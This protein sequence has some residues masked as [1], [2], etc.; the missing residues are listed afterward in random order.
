M[1]FFRFYE[2]RPHRPE[3]WLSKNKLHRLSPPPPCTRGH[4]RSSGEWAS[5]PAHHSWEAP[6][7]PSHFE[8]TCNGAGRPNAGFV[9][10]RGILEESSPEKES[11]EEKCTGT[12]NEVIQVA[13]TPTTPLNALVEWMASGAELPCRVKAN[14]DD[15]RQAQELL[16]KREEA[17]A[18]SSS[19]PLSLGHATPPTDGGEPNG[20][21][22]MEPPEINATK[23]KNS[24]ARLD[25]HQITDDKTVRVGSARCWRAAIWQHLFCCRTRT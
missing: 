15:V 5:G 11:L 4:R 16:Q 17:Q 14:Y 24:L 12:K 18:S 13:P 21:S 7:P 22:P 23:R 20:D 9:N 2:E 3:R 8:S 10:L 6:V 19:R 25:R 1:Y